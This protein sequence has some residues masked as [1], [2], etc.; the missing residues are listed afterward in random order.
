M[1]LSC[2]YPPKKTREFKGLDATWSRLQALFLQS[3]PQLASPNTGKSGKRRAIP[4]FAGQSSV[5]SC[6]RRRCLCTRFSRLL[7]QTLGWRGIF[8]GSVV[9]KAGAG[10]N[11]ATDYYVFLQAAQIVPL[12]HDCS[13]GQ[14]PGRFLERSRRNEGISRQRC[15]GNP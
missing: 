2:P 5:F 13:F 9:G 11:Q 7:K 15:L 4:P 6:F 10:R 1:N 12:T 3:L 8:P 14:N